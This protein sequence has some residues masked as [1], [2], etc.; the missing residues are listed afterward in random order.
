M[1]W[2]PP[3]QNFSDHEKE[4]FKNIIYTHRQYKGN[5]SSRDATNYGKSK[6]W[7]KIQL[8]K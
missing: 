7:I 3:Y 8:G 5:L 1:F 2:Y 6:H 4:V